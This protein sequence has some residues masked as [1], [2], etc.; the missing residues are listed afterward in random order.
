MPQNDG[1]VGVSPARGGNLGREFGQLVEARQQ[2]EAALQSS[3]S[4]L[5]AR[6]MLILC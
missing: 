3:A 1:Q 4:H 2:F 5:G 6:V